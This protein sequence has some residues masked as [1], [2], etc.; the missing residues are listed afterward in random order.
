MKQSIQS[1]AKSTSTGIDREIIATLIRDKMNKEELSLRKAA[2]EAKCSPATFSRLLSATGSYLPDTATL[3]SV[4]KWLRVN[5]AA[6][7]S[8]RRPS[9]ASIADVEVYLHALPDLSHNDAQLIMS[10]VKTLYEQKRSPAK[11]QE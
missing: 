9:S 4:A 5:V 6:F 3:N 10:V 8:S 7:E 2:D 11:T 1:Q